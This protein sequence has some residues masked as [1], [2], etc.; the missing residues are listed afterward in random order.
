MMQEI[1][2]RHVRTRSAAIR[3]AGKTV[4][5]VKQ[6][7]VA[8]GNDGATCIW[9]VRWTKLDHSH[10]KGRLISLVPAMRKG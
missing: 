3:S 8:V 7:R 4:G 1:S 9:K 6:S 5:D 10:E 2:L